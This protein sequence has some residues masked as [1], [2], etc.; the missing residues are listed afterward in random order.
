[1]ITGSGDDRHEHITVLLQS[2]L[3]PFGVYMLGAYEENAQ[4]EA[5]DSFPGDH[6]ESIVNLGI[7]LLI[8][9][10]LSWREYFSSFGFGSAISQKLIKEKIL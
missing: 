6:S 3:F 2:G 7:K 5:N 9:R 1:V 8:F 4:R 10:Q